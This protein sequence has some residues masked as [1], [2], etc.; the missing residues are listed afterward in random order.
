MGF[1][2]GFGRDTRVF[3]LCKYLES[4]L[5]SEINTLMDGLPRTGMPDLYRALCYA[6]FEINLAL[7]RILVLPCQIGD[8]RSSLSSNLIYRQ[9]RIKM[10]K[11][12]CCIN[13][14]VLTVVFI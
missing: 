12:Y 13:Y 2:K 4:I 8:S 11:L 1:R 10:I 6:L 9:L 5:L 14:M 3:N 7:S